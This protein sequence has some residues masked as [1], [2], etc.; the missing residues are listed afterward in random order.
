MLEGVVSHSY[1]PKVDRM[2][3]ARILHHNIPIKRLEDC[4]TAQIHVYILQAE[5]LHPYV[6][7]ACI[8]HATLCPNCTSAGQPACPVNQ[9]V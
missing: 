8:L 2:R 5:N 4:V 6:L 9:P 7:N 3:N 1:V